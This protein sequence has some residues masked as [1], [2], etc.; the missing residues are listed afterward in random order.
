MC[1]HVFLCYCTVGQGNILLVVQGL[2]QR[3]QIGFFSE[4]GHDF[5]EETVMV[6]KTDLL[7]NISEQNFRSLILPKTAHPD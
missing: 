7:P 3:D 6:T 5:N 1:Y 4:I 2:W